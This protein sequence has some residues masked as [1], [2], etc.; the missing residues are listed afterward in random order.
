VRRYDVTPH[1]RCAANALVHERVQSRE[2]N[3]A[4]YCAWDGNAILA[5]VAFCF[6]RG[7]AAAAAN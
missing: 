5:R 1:N 3:I 7:A 2:K 4:F 6:L